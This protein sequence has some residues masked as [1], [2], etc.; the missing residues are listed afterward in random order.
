MDLS[1]GAVDSIWELL[2]VWNDLTGGIVSP[3]DPVGLTICECKTLL[4]KPFPALANRSLYTVDVG[5]FIT[6]VFETRD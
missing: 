1:R 3:E 5:V 6:C 2:V 4:E